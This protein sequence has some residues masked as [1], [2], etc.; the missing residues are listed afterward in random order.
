MLQ[1]Y[2]SYVKY[3]LSEFERKPKVKAIIAGSFGAF[4][5]LFIQKIV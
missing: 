3:F 5:F 4:E 1:Y 2:A